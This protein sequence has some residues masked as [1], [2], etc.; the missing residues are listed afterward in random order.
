MLL[1]GVTG[2][3]AGLCRMPHSQWRPAIG[4]HPH[5]RPPRHRQSHRPHVPMLMRGTTLPTTHSPPHQ[6]HLTE[7]PPNL[8]PA[9]VIEEEQDWRDPTS[10]RTSMRAASDCRPPQTAWH[11]S[12]PSSSTRQPP[13]QKEAVHGELHP[14]KG[15]GTSCCQQQ[16]PPQ[17]DAAKMS[18]HISIGLQPVL[19]AHAQSQPAAGSHCPAREGSAPH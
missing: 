13:Q 17:R 6:S 2:A 18:P 9:T 5:Q 16:A 7:N 1:G 12:Q 14:G 19:A 8:Q 15:K 10:R 11:A 4:G 3:A